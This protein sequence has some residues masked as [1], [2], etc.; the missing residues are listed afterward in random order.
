METLTA[1]FYVD[2]YF[3]LN[4][5]MDLVTCAV[6]ALIC[7]E[8]PRFLR[9]VAGAL[10]GGVVALI[11]ALCP[12]PV[13]ARLAISLLSFPLMMFITFG[14]KPRRRFLTLLLFGF[15]TAL[16]LGG[17]V[18]WLSYLSGT[19]PKAVR[20]TLLSFIALTGGGFFLWSLWGV[21]MKKRMES[22]VISLSVRV[23][24]K[25][26]QFYG[27]VDSGSFLRDPMSGDP[28]ILLKASSAVEIL[29]AEEMARLHEEPDGTVRARSIPVRGV[30]GTGRVVAFRPDKVCFHSCGKRQTNKSVRD[31]LIALDFSGGGFAGCPCLVPLAAL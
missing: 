1:N 9:L 20:I 5:A 11:V 26:A 28:V 10:F 6:T 12:M 16:F 24:D 2:T 31:I 15:L 30:S 19:N 17:A 23:R 7:M 27:L 18:T 13:P 14:K 8:K 3:L 22:T 4:T 25:E 21:R 29:S